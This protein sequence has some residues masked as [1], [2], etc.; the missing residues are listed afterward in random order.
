M[1]LLRK[2]GLLGSAG[3][4]LVEL[5]ISMAILA[6][7]G[8]AIGGAMYV[9]SRSY[10]RGSAEV[11]VQEEAQ[12]SA[13]LICDWLIDATEVTQTSTDNLTITHPEGADT[14]V[15][16]IFRSGDKV[17]YTVTRNG[18]PLD[19]ADPDPKVLCDYVTGVVF[20]S[21][22]DVDR[23][24]KISMD[25]NVNNRT[26]HAVTDSTSRNH[27]FISTGGGAFARNPIIG[28]NI[29]PVAG[30]YYVVL[31]PG[32][33]D[34]HSAAFEFEATIYNPDPNPANNTLTVSSTGPMD[35]NLILTRQGTTNKWTVKAL[36][37]DNALNDKTFTF[38]ATKTLDDGTTLTDSKDVTV[39]IRRATKC[40]F[41]VTDYASLAAGN[42]GKNGS[43]YNA[44]T[45]D[46]GIQHKDR[47]S[48]GAAYDSGTFGYKDPSVV[49]YYY[50]FADGSDA[51][52]CVNATEV[53]S[54]DALSVQVS[55]TADI[56]RDLYVIAVVPHSGKLTPGAL[57][58]NTGCSPLNKVTDISHSDFTYTGAPAANAAY[59]D[60]FKIQ[61]G[62]SGGT[63]VNVGAGFQRGSQAFRLGE[64]DAQ[65]LAKVN[66]YIANNGGDTRYK[67]I[68]SFRYIPTDGSAPWSNRSVLTITQATVGHNQYG[69]WGTNGG[70]TGL[71]SVFD[72]D[73]A[74]TIEVFYDLYDTV[75]NTYVTDCHFQNTGTLNACD[76]YVY[77]KST[78]AF[79]KSSATSVGSASNPININMRSTNPEDKI[80]YVDYD[81]LNALTSQPY[82][83][84]GTSYV[85]YKYKGS[86][87]VNDNANWTS[88]NVKNP[89][90]QG[91]ADV[92]IGEVK[93]V[94]VNQE[95]WPHYENHKQVKFGTTTTKYMGEFNQNI[96]PDAFITVAKS[97]CQSYQ[98]SETGLYKVEFS[99]K[100]VNGQRSNITNNGSMPS[101]SNPNGSVMQMGTYNATREP[102]GTVYYKINY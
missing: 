43:S 84:E 44:V 52:S 60:Y 11:N 2:K 89:T 87:D 73:K 48:A 72:C 57:N 62:T 79:E 99:T 74:Y 55:L 56:N 30:Q 91:T 36:S 100:R 94:Y 16:N 35:S 41:S 66:T 1:K 6:V 15:I 70:T 31:E 5:L 27:D 90:I 40:E 81:S 67:Q 92:G 51:S 49:Q 42:Q 61:K 76:Q 86:G 93:S 21:T 88:T 25:F 32:Q 59:W 69:V 39:L 50:R 77:D 63:I 54:G 95:G 8:T 80:F 71:T 22:F 20:T 34:T 23:N 33:N 82:K 28:F 102:L 10:T 83:I 13:N 38:T 19:P 75:T 58:Y 101:A 64:L 53:T 3:L 65:A 29:P 24:V 14:D 46:L 26:Y 85:V 7:V 18:S 12:V 97:D 4:T 45:L 98:T 9:S 96:Y 68:V 37:D 17:M 78:G 47:I